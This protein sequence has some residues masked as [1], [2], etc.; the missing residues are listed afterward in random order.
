[1]T[2]VQVKNLNDWQRYRH[3]FTSLTCANGHKT[4]EM[5]ARWLAL[6]EL[7]SITKPHAQR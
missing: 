1:M 7:Q 2:D 5:H 4:L 6:P 3:A